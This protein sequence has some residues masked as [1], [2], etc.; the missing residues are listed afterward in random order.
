MQLQPQPQ[1]Q[2]NFLPHTEAT[3]PDSQ[4]QET[5]LYHSQP[6]GTQTLQSQAGHSQLRCPQKAQVTSQ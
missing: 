1:L 6:V 4:P 3:Q 5:Q 2:E